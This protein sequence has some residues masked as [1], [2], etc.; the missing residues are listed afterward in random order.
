MRQRLRALIRVVCGM[1]VVVVAA[2]VLMWLFGRES[3]VRFRGIVDS[4]AENVGPVEAARIVSIEVEPGRR[5]KAGDVLVRFDPAALLAEQALNDV[6]IRE[7]E[8]SEERV[9]ENLREA[10]RRGRQAVGEASVA[11]E[12]RRMERLREQAELAALDAEIAR[13]KPLVE[14]KLVSELELVALR[15]KADALRG[16]VGGYEPLL[17]ALEERLREARAGLKEL[18]E[19]IAAFDARASSSSNATLRAALRRYEEIHRV[20]SSA[21]RALSDGVVSQVFR[22][23]GDIVP[24]GEAIVRLASAPDARFVTGMLPADHLDDVH[25]GDELVVSRAVI[26]GRGAHALSAMGRVE[27]I[28]PEVLDFFDPMNPAP[29]VPVRGRKVHIRLIGAVAAFIPGETVLISGKAGG[30]GFVERL[31]QM[32]SLRR[33]KREVGS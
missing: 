14:K 28:D 24:A 25:V 7:C 18:E 6:K 26:P 13:L 1:A 27:T 4:G 8:Q 11:L 9:R 17:K 22:R 21:L 23:V 16:T 32:F 29:R 12:E 2:A 10:V 30:E 5:V 20:D 31:A 33:M 15:P 3:E 19:E